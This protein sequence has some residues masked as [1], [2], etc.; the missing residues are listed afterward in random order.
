MEMKNYFH[1]LFFIKM[2]FTGSLGALL[3][4]SGHRRQHQLPVII[5][6]LS[7]FTFLSSP[8]QPIRAP[9]VAGLLPGAGLHPPLPVHG[10]FRADASAGAALPDHHN[11]I[12]FKCLSK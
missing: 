1:K 10:R 9:P 3:G 2:Q 4:L 8:R 6:F 12:D 5:P 11:G 7:L